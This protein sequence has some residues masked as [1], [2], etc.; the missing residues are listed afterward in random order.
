MPDIWYTLSS[1]DVLSLLAIS[2]PTSILAVYISGISSKYAKR[3]NWAVLG[4]LTLLL[5]PIPF[6][7]QSTSSCNSNSGDWFCGFAERIIITIFGTT[8][9]CFTLFYAVSV[10]VR[11]CSIKF[12]IFLVSAEAILLVMLLLGSVLLFNYRM[13]EYELVS[14]KSELTTTEYIKLCESF[15]NNKGDRQMINK[16][17]FTAVQASTG[18]DICS[19]ATKGQSD[20]RFALYAT[21]IS[22]CDTPP[23]FTSDSWV[24]IDTLGYE[25]ITSC[26]KNNV[27]RYPGL[28]AND[29]ADMCKRSEW[30]V[31]K[32][33]CEDILN[34]LSQ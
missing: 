10:T 18:V 19:L 12:A 9:F 28:T 22:S 23:N 5:L 32:T 21:I 14:G 16:C 26:W 1:G 33:K 3:R 8:A 29:L 17:W 34:V 2:I 30:N 27:S 11:K 4:L 25:M 31:E 24:K 15:I 7:L 13:S 6:L 20:C